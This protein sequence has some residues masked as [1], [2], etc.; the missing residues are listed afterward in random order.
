MLRTSQQGI[1]QAD[2][3]LA[4]ARKAASRL[5]RPRLV[6]LSHGQPDGARALQRAAVSRKAF[7]RPARPR[8]ALQALG[9]VFSGLVNIDQG[10]ATFSNALP[11]LRKAEQKN[12]ASQGWPRLT[13]ALQGLAK[14]SQGLTGL[15]WQG[16]RA[17]QRPAVFRKAS[18]CS[19]VSRTALQV[20]G[21]AYQDL[22]GLRQ[23]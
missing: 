16:L 10:S 15:T 17:W 20:L 5:G 22:P 14:L 1:S 21:Q 18:Q 7:Q 2:P 3:G 11:W 8:K 4:R 9:Q 6:G 13:Q 12:E 23:G 19:A